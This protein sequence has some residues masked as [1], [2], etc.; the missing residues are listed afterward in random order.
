VIIIFK[1]NPNIAF[2]VLK[3][4]IN[5]ANHIK[6]NQSGLDQAALNIVDVIVVND[7]EDPHGQWADLGCTCIVV[8]SP[9]VVIVCIPVQTGFI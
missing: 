8:V 6:T 5:C 3:V 2:S 7:S 9:S 1:F 4:V